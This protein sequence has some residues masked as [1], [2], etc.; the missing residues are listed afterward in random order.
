MIKNVADMREE[1]LKSQQQSMQFIID[2]IYDKIVQTC[3]EKKNHLCVL[4]TKPK[5]FQE[6]NL[7][8]TNPIY[9][10]L[11]LNPSFTYYDLSD[12]ILIPN[13]QVDLMKEIQKSFC[14]KNYSHMKL[15]YKDK[16]QTTEVGCIISW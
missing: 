11:H 14:E 1:A 3:A 13:S 2:V 12:R 9:P 15:L 16:G 8:Y 5:N 6:S 10:E 4:I 7:F